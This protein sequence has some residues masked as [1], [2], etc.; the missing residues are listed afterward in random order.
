[1]V[2]TLTVTVGPPVG[3]GTDVPGAPTA[4]LFA[5]KDTP[6]GPSLATPTQLDVNRGQVYYLDWGESQADTFT[7]TGPTS[8]IPGGSMT[9]P[10]TERVTVNRAFTAPSSPQTYNHT[11]QLTGAGGS[12]S[13]TVAIRVTDTP[14]DLPQPRVPG[15]S[16]LGGGLPNF[17]GAATKAPS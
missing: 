16:F 11:L 10:F 9:V 6:T 17:G 4:T 12:A 13:A 8:V 5:S 7:L 1:V 3:P 14:A 15:P 2:R